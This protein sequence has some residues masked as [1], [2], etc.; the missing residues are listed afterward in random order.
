M[1]IRPIA[2]ALFLIS[3][4]APAALAQSSNPRD[5]RTG[6]FLVAARK[7]PDPTFAQTVIV[8]TRFSEDGAMG[9]IINRQTNVPMARAVPLARSSDPVYSGGPV[10]APTVYGLLRS[11]SKPDQATPVVADIYMVAE[12][13]LLEK[14]VSTSPSADRFRAY[15]GY[16]GWGPGQLDHEVE[17]GAWFIFSG[18]AEMVFDTEPES[19]WTRLVALT[20][21]QIAHSFPTPSR[22]VSVTR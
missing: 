6:K 1:Q 9:L 4:G 20:E 13:A 17:L 10:G 12:R 3:V 11:P 15:L 19:L 21:R 16:C 18:R 5:L 7:F 2:L 8:L 14:T 22:H